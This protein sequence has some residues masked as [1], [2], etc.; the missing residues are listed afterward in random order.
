MSKLH[1]STPERE[2][3]FENLTPIG[4]RNSTIS[5]RIR[6]K[7][8]E[9]AQSKHSRIPPEASSSRLAMDWGL[10]IPVASRFTPRQVN[11]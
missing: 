1:R 9:Q 7:L 3:S 4:Q 11:S 6:C 8:A 10:R 5:F 2:I